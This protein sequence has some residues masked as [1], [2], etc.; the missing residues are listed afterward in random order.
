MKKFLNWCLSCNHVIN[1]PEKPWTGP[2]RQTRRRRC[3]SKFAISPIVRVWLSLG[4][5]PCR[6]DLS[7]C[8]RDRNRRALCW[9]FNSQIFG[10]WSRVCADIVWCNKIALHWMN[11]KKTIF[12]SEWDRKAE[13]VCV[14]HLDDYKLCLDVFFFI[15]IWARLRPLHALCEKIIN[16]QWT[17]KWNHMTNEQ[18]FIEAS[19]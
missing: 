3:S 15:S 6:R 13:K 12:S 17:W 14:L 19:R 8:H 16:Q 4:S 10:N 9:L 11:E 2:W 5:T 7:A 18:I 1:S